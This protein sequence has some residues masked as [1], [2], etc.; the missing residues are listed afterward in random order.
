MGRVKTVVRRAISAHRRS[1]PV[2]LL[3]G[4]TSFV[5]AAYSNEGSSFALNGE[6]DLIHNLRAANFKIAFDVGAIGANG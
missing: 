3:H 5:E 1:A 2:R 6:Y 4:V